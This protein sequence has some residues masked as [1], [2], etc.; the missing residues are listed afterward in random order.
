MKSRYVYDTILRFIGVISRNCL[1]SYDIQSFSCL[2]VGVM[3]DK[4][5]LSRILKYEDADPAGT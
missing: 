1:R 3:F 4:S 5:V 2:D